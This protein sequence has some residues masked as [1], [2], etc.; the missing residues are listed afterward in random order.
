M[1]VFKLV[2]KDKK[3]NKLD[4]YIATNI[5]EAIEMLK[6]SQKLFDYMLSQDIT[7]SIEKKSN[8]YKM[9]KGT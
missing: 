7:I 3:D 6:S 2:L 9:D 5:E 1:N 8:L 4:F